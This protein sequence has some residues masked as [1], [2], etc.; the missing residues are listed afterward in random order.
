[1]MRKTLLPLARA[2]RGS[3]AAVIFLAA[4]PAWAQEEPE[5]TAP[6]EAEAAPA[7]A[8]PAEGE[9]PADATGAADVAPADAAAE[10][11]TATDTIPVQPTDGGDATAAADGAT[12]LDTV[13]VTGSRIKRTDYETAQPVLVVRREDI[14]RTGLS[15]IGDLLQDLA[16]AGSALNTSINNGGTGAIE[17]DLRNLGSG[18]VLVL[19][20]GHRWVNG[21]RALGTNAVDLTT[22]PISL[23]ERIEVLKDGASAVYGS[24]AIAGVVNIITRKDFQGAEFRTYLGNALE[25]NGLTQSHN[26]SFGNV[27]GDTGLFLDLSFVRQDGIFLADTEMF[28]TN[29]PGTGTSRGSGSSAQGRFVFAPNAANRSALSAIDPASCSTLLGGVL[30]DVSLN[31]GADGQDITN[32]HA[33]G[34]AD[35]YETSVDNYLVTPNERTSLFGQVTHQLTPDIRMSSELL[36]NLRRSRQS[37]APMPIQVGDLVAFPPFGPVYVDRTNIYNPFDQDIGRAAGGVP[38]A[39]GFGAALRRDIEGGRRVF[40]QEVDTLRGGLALNGALD[41]A[42][43]LLNWEVGYS[44]G[45]SKSTDTSNGLLNMNRVA[46]A[47]GPDLDCTNDPENQCV[48][49]NLF[50]SGTITQ[51]MLDYILYTGT[52]TTRQD[53]NDVYGNFSIDLVDFGTGMVSMAFGAEYRDEGYVN[54]PDPLVSQG[55]SSTNRAKPTGGGYDVKEAFLEF[56]I[57]LASGLQWVDALDLSVAGRTSDYGAYGKADT[58]KLGLRHKPIKDLLL[59][60]TYSTAFRAPSVG[61]L[62]LGNSDSFSGAIDPCESGGHNDAAVENCFTQDGL[63]P[64]IVQ[65]LPQILDVF[66]GNQRLEPEDAKTLTAGFVYSPEYLPDFNFYFDWYRIEVDNYIT[67]PG[68]QYIL[69]ACYGTTT[70]QGQ[71]RYCDQVRRDPVSGQVTEVLDPFLNFAELETEGFD[72]TIDYLLPWFRDYGVFKVLA[73]GTYLTKYNITSFA[74]DGTPIVDEYA[75]THQP[76][77]AF[78]RIRSTAALDWGMGN[79]NASWTIRYVHHITEP[80]VDGL[81]PSLH[82]L[83]LCSDPDPNY[84]PDDTTTPVLDETEDAST[85]QLSEKFYNNVLVGYMFTDYATKLEFGINNVLDQDPDVSYLFSPVYGYEPTMYEAPGRFPFIRLHKTF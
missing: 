36:Y 48:P 38:L 27:S 1:M 10:A 54:T 83:G 30:C 73:D 23:V 9:A 42:A 43:R 67:I 59:R 33:Y 15:S 29:I 52:S 77:T 37:L 34:V 82:D 45:E 84:V 61:E 46:K 21:L 17:I 39:E 53:V 2:A 14:E 51:Q 24:D 49:L 7:E 68:A 74:P 5:A 16:V 20:N 11:G 63:P 60:S 41:M 32:Y 75:G 28:K 47:L 55:I 71:R 6:A 76:F 80:C 35:N 81:T 58:Y 26:V 66:Q 72:I 13:E 69:D 12:K 8:A 57:P 4:L 31:V 3:I 56:A 64:T 85:N 50:G 65:L 62:F 25:G 18:R 70:D 19:V 40:R 78:P 44:Y 79:W 22:V